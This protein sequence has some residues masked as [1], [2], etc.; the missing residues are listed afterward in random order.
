M[1]M[2]QVQKQQIPTMEENDTSTIDELAGLIYQV[3]LGKYP[4]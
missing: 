2:N 3:I 1:N 4:K